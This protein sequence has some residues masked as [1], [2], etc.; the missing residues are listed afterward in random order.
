V[1][2][3]H[4][5]WNDLR[6]FLAAA[7]ARTLAGAARNLNV[8]HSTI[9]R[10]LSALERSLGGALFVRG[11]D[12]LRLTLLG[13]K[14]VPLAEEIELSIVALEKQ[15][16][17]QVATV[18]LAVPSGF[19]PQFT[20]YLERLRGSHPE[21]S[22]EFV[23]GS[24]KVDLNKNEAELALRVGAAGDENLVARKVGDVGWSLYASPAYLAR[25][26]KPTGPD[27]LAGHEVLGFDASLA[28]LP[29][30]KW[31]AEH[32]KGAAVVL[33]HREL[34]D[35]AA[36]A[37]GGAGLAL[38]PCLF[39]PD[40]PKLVRLTPQVLGRQTISLVYR[41]EALLAKPVQVVARFVID[42]MRERAK[43][44]RG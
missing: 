35:M 17:E 34:A 24:R 18:R 20:P 8:K 39:A 2:A 3:G 6:Y 25:R 19:V 4:F 41:R 36:A 37:V 38:L 12:G 21:I 9:G 27:K 23:S 33:L 43:A 31:L 13:E 16:G 14:L 30:A 7:R 1:G 44:M 10:R 32:G 11:S 5:D 28:G 22:L 42:V 40:Y 29:G 15:V 26:G